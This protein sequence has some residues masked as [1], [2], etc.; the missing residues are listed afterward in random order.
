MSI[1]YCAYDD[2]FNINILIRSIE[3][4][5]TFVL[6]RYR[7]KGISHLC[8][9]LFKQLKIWIIIVRAAVHMQIINF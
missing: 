6:P 8:K 2:R 7:K 5:R 4:H 1:A 3:V 9:S